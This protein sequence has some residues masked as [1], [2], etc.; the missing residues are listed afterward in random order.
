M[1]VA[2]SLVSAPPM[3]EFTFDPSAAPF[4]SAVRVDNGSA[5][6]GGRNRTRG[7]GNPRPLDASL[8]Q[9]NTPQ[10]GDGAFL[11]SQ[12]SNATSQLPARN[13][14][15]NGARREGPIDPSLQGSEQRQ[16]TRMRNRGR[17]TENEPPVSGDHQRAGIAG[18]GDGSVGGIIRQGAA[19]T[20]HAAAEQGQEGQATGHD[21]PPRNRN[22]N[23][24]NKKP[25][26]AEGSAPPP[27]SSNVRGE[28]SEPTHQSKRNHRERQPQP[29]R[30]YNK[31][32]ANARRAAFGG[33]LSSYAVKG[34]NQS[35][36]DDAE[37]Q[38][39]E[40]QDRAMMG[41][42]S[43]DRRNVFGMTKEADDLA[44]KL[45]RGLTTRPFLECPICFSDLLP[46]QAI[47]SCLPTYSSTDSTSGDTTCCYT[48]FHL[49]CMQDWSSRSL[50]EARER[51]RDR[52]PGDPAPITWRCPGC[53]KHRE[54]TVTNYQCFCGR[55]KHLK[56]TEE[57]RGSGSIAVPHSCGQ[58]CSRKR[59]YCDHPC[60]LPC[61]PGP[62]PPCNISLV[63]PCASHE[64]PL[65]VK[66]STVRGANASAP[67]C[68][69]VHVRN[70]RFKNKSRVSV[71]QSKRASSVDGK[72][73][74]R[75]N[76]AYSTATISESGAQ[77][78]DAE[79]SVVGCT[80]AVNILVRSH[81]ILT[82]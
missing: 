37:N 41:Y 47:W 57:N 28:S 82:R 48:P 1:A 55:I 49:S 7:R 63:I 66:C 79:E 11:A 23:N 53:Q 78:L 2:S 50:K 43:L 81:V 46:S 71:A 72:R 24:R 38:F 32:P 3:N 6:R 52:P 29:N 18:Q 8:S 19:A 22:R 51:A 76:V 33:K 31:P 16:N 80:I 14:R 59:N 12:S 39:E 5:S 58:S 35:H 70:A 27:A 77:G 30:G 61:H 74:T 4:A 73:Q 56:A 21:R 67:T 62:C 69:E 26:G 36:D 68:D 25:N 17:R 42:S 65:A 20:S 54:S 45:I 34:Q 13:P 75:W 9:H 40:A 15:R 60:P 64:H 44:S 10:P